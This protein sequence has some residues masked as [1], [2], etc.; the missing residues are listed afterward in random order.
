M[1]H[2]KVHAERMIGYPEWW[3][4][5]RYDHSADFRWTEERLGYSVEI[6]E[7]IKANY[8]FQP[9]L[10]AAVIAERYDGMVSYSDALKWVND[11]IQGSR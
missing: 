6:A 7:L 8:A 9:E 4:E 3:W 1:D 2:E 5:F 11:T 10:V